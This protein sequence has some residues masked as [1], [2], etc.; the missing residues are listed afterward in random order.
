MASPT[1]S[2]TVLLASQSVAAGATVTSSWIDC[3]S[4]FEMAAKVG[5]AIPGGAPSAGPTITLNLSP[6][7]GTT[8][9]QVQSFAGLTSA[10]SY[11]LAIDDAD[12][13]VQMSVKNN[14]GATNAITVVA[15]LT[16]IDTVA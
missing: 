9:Y 5:I 6:D 3:R 4:F 16:H 8:V 13:Y 1:K 15:D 7:N 12:M 10:Q 14:D 2:R 11:P